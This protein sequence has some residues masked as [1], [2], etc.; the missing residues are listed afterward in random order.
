MAN[1][2]IQ[3]KKVTYNTE[4]VDDLIDRSFS[5]LTKSKETPTIQSLFNLYNELFYNLPKSGGESHTSLIRR[6]SEFVG[7]IESAK[8]I[9]IEDL[10][11]RVTEL[12][13]ELNQLNQPDEEHPFFSNGT[14]LQNEDVYWD[15]Y[16]MDKGRKRRIIGD[17]NGEVFK[18]LKSALGFKQDTSEKDIV[19]VIPSSILTG[20]KAGPKLDIEDIIGGNVDEI[21]SLHNTIIEL[22][23]SDNLDPNNFSSVRDYQ[24]NLDKEIDEAW[25]LEQRLEGLRNKHSF[26]KNNAFDEEQRQ[27]A[28]T[29][30]KATEPELDKVR[31]KLVRLRKL[32][33]L[34]LS[35]GALT[36][37][38]L[39]A[40][41]V[42]I[43]TTSVS[44]DEQNEFAGWKKGDFRQ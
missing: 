6:S 38:Q 25:N 13:E 27:N 18:G 12:E 43:S 14:I 26:D 36:M 39:S 23:P 15:Y 11:E 4:G 8:D 31:I 35:P 32:Y 20:I 34:L 28:I 17:Q 24:I 1:Q 29:L 33:E 40:Q 19:V 44:N 7:S 9:Q 42:T 37:K 10:T 2:K 21:Q 22:D 5:E 3:L 41:Y 30:Q 16:Y